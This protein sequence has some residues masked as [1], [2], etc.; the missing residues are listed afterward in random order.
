MALPSVT[1]IKRA[2]VTDTDVIVV[3]IPG[4]VSVEAAQNIKIAIGRVWPNNQCLVL[5]D[6]MQ[7]KVVAENR[8]GPER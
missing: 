8:G 2:P 3:E 4:Q 5:C 1:V 6:G 7:I